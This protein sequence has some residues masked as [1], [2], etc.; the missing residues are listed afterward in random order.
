MRAY[1]MAEAGLQSADDAELIRRIARRDRQAFTTLYRRYHPRLHGYLRRLLADPQMAEEVF[2]DVMFVVWK[3]AQRFAG[4]SAASSWIF[5]IAY[6]RAM[7]ALRSEARHQSRVDR[8]ASPER[9][10]G[11][12][13]GSGDLIEAALQRL[14]PN[15]RQVVE[16]TY[17]FGFSCKEIAEIAD[18]PVN[19]VKTRMFHARKRLR[20]LVPEL[21]GEN[22]DRQREQ[23]P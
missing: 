22:E 13:S 12:S 5:G 4:A 18:C 10:A 8:N 16:L 21:A 3:D 2:D 7:S 1:A 9:I 20:L 11:R 19:T 15:H 23:K 17:F 14:S 6:R